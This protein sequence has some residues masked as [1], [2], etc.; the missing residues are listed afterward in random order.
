MMPVYMDSSHPC[1]MRPQGYFYQGFGNSSQHMSMDAPPPCYGSC[2]HGNFPAY[3]NAYWPPC[4]PAQVPYHQCC[5]NHSGFHPH[6]GAYAP[7][8]YLHPPFPVGYQQAWYDPDKDVPG[9]PVGYHC[10]KCSPQKNGSGVVIEEHEPEI[11]KGNQGEAA[12]PVR[13]TNCPYPIIWIP[14]EYARNQEHGNSLGSGNHNQP[15]AEVKAP[16]NMTIQKK[17]PKSWNGCFPFDESAMKSLVPNQDGKKVRQNGKTVELPFD[18]SKLR[19]LLQGQDIKEAQIQK[20]KE[21]SGQ[22]Q[23]PTSWIPSRGKLD[24]VDASESSNEDMKNMQNGKTVKCPF[25]M[26]KLNSLFQ[27]QDVKEGQTQKNKEEPGQLP[28]HKFWIPSY[29]KWE[30]VEASESKDSGNKGVNPS[31][32]HGNEG[33]TNQKEGGEGNFESNVLSD[34]EEKSSVRNIPVQNYLQ[35][36]RNIPVK[37]SESHLPKP[38]EPTKTIAKNEPVKNTEKKQ[39]L[40]SPK[41]SR[42]PPVC[43]RVDPLPKK[44]NGGSKSLSPPKQKEESITSEETKDI[45][46][47]RSKKAESMTVPEA[48][49]VKCE[50]ANKELKMPEGSVHAIGTEEE[51]VESNPNLQERSNCE[52]VKPCQTKENKEQP[53]KK[54]FTQEEAARIIQTRYRGYDVRRWEPIKKLKEIATIREQ[55]GDVKNRIQALEVSTDQHIEEKEIVVLGEMVMNLLLKVDAVQGLHPSIRDY[56]KSLARELSGIQEKLDSVKSSSDIVKK[57]VVN[58]QLLINSQPC[59]SSMN[60]EHSQL[61]EENKMVSDSNTEKVHVLSPVDHSMSVLYRT[62]EQPNDEA[63]EGSGLFETLATDPKQTTETEAAASSTPIPEKMGEGDIVLPVNPLLADGNRMTLTNVEENKPVVESLEE[64]LKELPQ[65]VEETHGT[66][67]TQDPDIASEASEAEAKESEKEDRKEDNDTVLPPEKDVE[68]SELPVGVID[69]ETQLLSQDSSSYTHETQVTAV[70][71]E[72]A[73]HEENDVYHLPDNSKGIGQE[74]SE[75]QDEIQQSPK[76]EVIVREESPETGVVVGEESQETE[77]VVKDQPQP[78]ETGVVKEQSP[79]TEAA[80]HELSEETKRLMEENKRFKETME[81]L[82]KAG[83][84]QLEVISKLT[85]RIKSLE[86]KLSRKKKTQIR[87]RATKPMSASSIDAVL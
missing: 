31:D 84:E 29:G 72:R 77:V 87:R 42:L 39:S 52:I 36:P 55:M 68:L 13:S 53:P 32:H 28:Y 61:A 17:F 23:Y 75:P 22:L 54:T 66:S 62:D 5:M 7:P 12:L 14:H 73:S 59:D 80:E 74:T 78:L 20:N 9:K 18:I 16:E 50:D 43:L 60:L 33:Q 35:E 8:C 19:S 63:E 47:L 44:R 86:K 83:R 37:L 26:S 34:A 51:I 57:E 70:E 21:E 81:T 40:S 64:P 46:S 58:E 56:R 76:T 48:C 1:Q 49:N 15:P 38:T 4:Y 85:G 67:S 69:D 65:V 27:G 71:P 45:S 10:G 6:H 2:V 82:V 30:D 41:A 3:N 24:D 11:D 79:E 25:D